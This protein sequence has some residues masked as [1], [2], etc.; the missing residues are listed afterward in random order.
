MF[1]LKFYKYNYIIY[2]KRLPITG[3][4]LSVVSINL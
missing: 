1:R 2:K 4:R 3:N